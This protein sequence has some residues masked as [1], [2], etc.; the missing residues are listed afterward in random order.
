LA[1]IFIY[2]FER[3][4]IMADSWILT[5]N[6]DNIVHINDLKTSIP[7]NATVDIVNYYYVIKNDYE[8]ND[9]DDLID[10]GLLTEVVRI[11]PILENRLVTAEIV[12][13]DNSGSGLTSDDVQEAVDEL[14]AMALDDSPKEVIPLRSFGDW[15][16]ISP[17]FSAGSAASMT[18]AATASAEISAGIS[19]ATE[20][21]LA[22][23]Y[24]NGA[25][26]PTANVAV[27]VYRAVDDTNY[28]TSSSWLFSETDAAGTTVRA[29]RRNLVGDRMSVVLTNNTGQTITS[30]AMRYRL[31][32]GG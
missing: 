28:E 20:I 18:A 19:G 12:E 24:V 15:A 11:L 2:L 3:K 32:T 22:W 23:E 8:S 17:T 30:V 25:G 21:E 9:I 6:T 1:N 13:Y 5:N 31:I 10:A 27:N 4:K 7:P 14:A 16:T 29:V 26:A